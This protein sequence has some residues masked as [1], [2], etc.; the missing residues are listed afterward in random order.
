MT[1]AG[2][3]VALTAAQ[4]LAP[5]AARLRAEDRALGAT[6][7]ALCERLAAVEPRV[8]A[9]LPEPGR[10]ERLLREAAA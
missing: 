9:F 6:V 3:E 8:R 4:P 1:L 7:E 5:L 10:R 2:A